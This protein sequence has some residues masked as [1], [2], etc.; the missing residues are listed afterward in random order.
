[1]CPS[2]WIVLFFALVTFLFHVYFRT[3]EDRAQRLFST[4]GM[5]PQT[6]KKSRFSRKE[7]IIIIAESLKHLSCYREGSSFARKRDKL[8]PLFMYFCYLGS[9]LL[10]C[11]VYNT[12][13]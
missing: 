8:V 13:T 10:L 6:M 5:I 9:F 2:S 4:K 1:M 11:S 3:L 7:E 12:E